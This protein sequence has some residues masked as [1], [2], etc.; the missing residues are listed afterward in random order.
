MRF[1]PSVI[2]GFGVGYL[3]GTRAG[4]E[5]Y[6]EILRWARDF[7]ERPEVQ[8]AAGLVFAQAGQVA[9]KV[10]GVVTH[11]AAGGGRHEGSTPFAGASGVH[12]SNGHGRPSSA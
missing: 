10:R 6:D 1:R 2:A 5:R 7:S 4:R 8:G 11:R 12:S 9:T 3:L